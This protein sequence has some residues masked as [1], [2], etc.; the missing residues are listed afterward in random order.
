M[1][2]FVRLGLIAAAKRWR[3]EGTLAFFHPRDWKRDDA[4]EA[5]SLFPA[6]KSGHISLLNPLPSNSLV[7]ELPL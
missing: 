4:R 7:H 3:E 6:E 2:F 5:L 1:A